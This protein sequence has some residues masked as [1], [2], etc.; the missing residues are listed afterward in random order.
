VQ[1]AA[2]PRLRVVCVDLERR[3]CFEQYV[4]AFE[5]CASEGHGPSV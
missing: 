2:F 1:A 4:R 3:E 5:Q